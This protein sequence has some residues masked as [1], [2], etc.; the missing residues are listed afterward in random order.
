MASQLDFSSFTLWQKQAFGAS[1]LQRMI[2]NYCYFSEATGFGDFR[3]IANQLDIVWQKLSALP[4]KFDPEKQL[5]KLYPLTPEPSSFDFFAVSPAVDVCTGMECLLTSFIDKN[6]DCGQELSTLSFAGVQNYIE[7]IELAQGIDEP[8]EA[9][10]LL[11]W[12]YET[13]KH[14]FQLVVEGKANKTSCDSLKKAAVG[15]RLSNIG[16]EY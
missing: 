4:I 8:E 6:S 12:E 10:L 7:F 2:P 15:E 11:E 1:L 13:Q 3:V 9:K 5:E 14:L 16:I